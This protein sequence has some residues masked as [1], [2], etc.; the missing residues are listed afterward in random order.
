MHCTT[1]QHFKP[2][3][4]PYVKHAYPYIMTCEKDYKEKRDMGSCQYWVKKENGN[5]KR[6]T[7]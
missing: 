4:A 1:C 2:T 3:Y 5:D 6:D 7:K